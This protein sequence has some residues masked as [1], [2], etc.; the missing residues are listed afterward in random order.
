VPIM[1][2]SF[3]GSSRGRSS[4]GV[5]RLATSL[6]GPRRNGRSEHMRPIGSGHELLLTF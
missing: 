2:G 3:V 1:S 6:P 5:E 4:R